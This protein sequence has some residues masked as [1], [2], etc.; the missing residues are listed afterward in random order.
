MKRRSFLQSLALATSG[1][2]LP[3]I[4]WGQEKRFEGITLNI[5]GYGGDYD[6]ILVETVA[7]PLEEQT[8]LTVMHT[9]STAAAATAR[10][11]ASPANPP[12]DL[13]MADSP[14]MPD[15]I[16]AE[17]ITPTDLDADLIA[18]LS[19]NI[20]EF[21]DHGIPMSASS[22]VLTH[23]TK[24]VDPPVESYADLARPDLE[25]RVATLNLENG[26]GVLFLLALAK[27]N[28][29][30]EDNVGP[31]FEALRRIKPNITSTTA[32]TVNLLQLFEQEEALAGPFWDGRVF[33]MQR[34]GKPMSLIVPVEG[35]Y[36]LRSYINP[37]KGTKHPEAVKA[38]L[39]QLLTGPFMTEMSRFFG[40][41]PTTRVQLP[42]DV[43]A[44]MIPYGE[45][46]LQNLQPVDWQ[47]VAAYRS[48][49]IAQFNREMR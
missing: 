44:N 3:N 28:G 5:N 14:N 27:A 7:K 15:L 31:G 38:Y 2:A 34:A 45:N 19:P 35:L 21:G 16:K 33:S 18:M 41:V 20:R 39:E 25:G 48:E 1:L 40:Y 8:G 23:N 36:G 32:S 30:S 37:V 29:G 10:I 22:M 12:F 46:G 4:A 6:R 26:G 13:I 24:L 49:W 17:A 42:P 43:A 9:P 47:K 11:L